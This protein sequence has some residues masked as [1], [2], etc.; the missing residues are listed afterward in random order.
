[1]SKP[2][3]HGRGR[4]SSLRQKAQS[5]FNP[6]ATKDFTAEARRRREEK[7]QRMQW[8][9]KESSFLVGFDLPSAVV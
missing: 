6:D 1:M 5:R 3:A 8:P 2:G 7:G 4:T 9:E